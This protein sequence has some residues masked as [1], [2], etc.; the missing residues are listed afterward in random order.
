MKK[1]RP[2]CE[3]AGCER[4]AEVHMYPL[5]DRFIWMYPE[6]TDFCSEHAGDREAA[7]QFSVSPSV[8][9]AKS[10]DD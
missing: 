10:P 2:S 1:D 5:V 9:R 7:G 4:L 6:G 3:D 8:N